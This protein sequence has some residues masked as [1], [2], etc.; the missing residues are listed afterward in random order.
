[1]EGRS[2]AHET[3]VIEEGY[4]A[5]PER[6]F[7]AF[8]DPA[9]KRIWFAD[10]ETSTVES[11]EMEFRVGG[12]ERTRFRSKEGWVF[13]NDTVYRDIVPNRRIVFAYNMSLG[14]ARISSSLVTIEFLPAETGTNLIFTEQAAFFEGAD[15]AR[16]REAGWRKLLG[17]LAKK[18]IPAQE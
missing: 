14:D 15:G 17:Y 11:F 7:N 9:T 12:S 13:T 8:A 3:Y 5:P 2:V 1:M 4:A 10:R 6:V 18:G 16:M